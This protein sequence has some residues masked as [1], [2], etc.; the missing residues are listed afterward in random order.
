[1][2]ADMGLRQWGISRFWGAF[3]EAGPKASASPVASTSKFLSP[4]SVAL[5]FV[6]V[7]DY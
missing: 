4:P 7:L 1:M 5:I 2:D 6:L 3:G